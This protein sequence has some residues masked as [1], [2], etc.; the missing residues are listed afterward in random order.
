[1]RTATPG[2]L[3]WLLAAYLDDLA[4]RNYAADTLR[5]KRRCL[6]QCI[7]Y[8]AE[9]DV[10][11]G[12]QVTRPMIERY[13]RHLFRHRKADGQP[14]GIKSQTERVKAVEMFFR[15]CVRKRHLPA[16]PASELD[17]PR[18]IRRLPVTLSPEEM[19]VVLRQPETATPWGVRDRAMLE[20]LYATGIRRM[21]LV[22][23]DTDDCDAAQRLLR[24]RQ[25]KGKKDRLV[26]LG[27]R[28]LAWI[29]RYLDDVRPRLLA[30]PDQR[31]LFLSQYGD[32]FHRGAL[33]ALVR[34]YVDAAEL[35]KTGSCHLFRH[36]MA[37][38][39]L[40]GGCDVRLIQEM[41]GHASLDTTAHY[42]RVS[43]RHLLQ[44][45][46]RCHPA[47]AGGQGAGGDAAGAGADAASGPLGGADGVSS[48]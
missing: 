5:S 38:A 32:R 29:Q 35:G 2:D 28:A 11:R 27:R 47:E 23:L 40:A 6:L 46:E 43:I 12:L 41:L 22:G 14:L 18:P 1:M 31:A 7:D 10:T 34:R 17:Y 20:T 9:R 33:G 3:C 42:A 26:P 37:S 45:H 4:R 44:A 36:S 48:P 25:G 24:I 8:L 30:D 13:Q 21:E 15:W 19:A 16:N 39:L